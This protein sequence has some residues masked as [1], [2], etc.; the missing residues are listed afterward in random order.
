MC[1]LC[2]ATGWACFAHR[3]THTAIMAR[4][5]TPIPEASRAASNATPLAEL[6]VLSLA[7]TAAQ[8][9]QLL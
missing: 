8:L 6:A 3:R 2:D 1:A 4:N 7:G 9:I 5:W